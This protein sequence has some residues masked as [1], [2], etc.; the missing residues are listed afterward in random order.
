MDLV[1]LVLVG[2]DDD[3]TV[4]FIIETIHEE[5]VCVLGCESVG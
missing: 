2:L 1:C 3:A 5:L 4:D